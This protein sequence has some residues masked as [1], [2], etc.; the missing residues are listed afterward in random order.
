METLYIYFSCVI[1]HNRFIH[2]TKFL[3]AL[4]AP[5]CQD[6]KNIKKIFLISMILMLH[7][8]V[9]FFLNLLEERKCLILLIFL[10]V[11][12]LGVISAGVSVPVQ[13][14]SQNPDLAGNYWPR[15]Q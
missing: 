2:V 15:L 9:F 3:L 13:I 11:Y 1:H 6:Y 5:D 8:N 10:F 4:N 12:I 14:P 7:L